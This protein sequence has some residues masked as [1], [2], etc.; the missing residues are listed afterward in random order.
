MNRKSILGGLAVVVLIGASFMLGRISLRY[1]SARV[2]S[3]GPINSDVCPRGYEP[4]DDGGAIKV[5]GKRAGTR[6]YDELVRVGEGNAAFWI[7]RYEASIWAD[8]LAATTQYGAKGHDFPEA[9][10][11]NGDWQSADGKAPVFA[12]SLKG[13]PPSANATWFQALSACM[14]SGKRLPNGDEWLRAAWGTKDPGEASGGNGECVTHN[15][16]VRGTGGGTRCRSRW[17]A[18]DMVGNLWEWTSEWYA[19]VADRTNVDLPSWSDQYGGD[20]TSNVGGT[21]EVTT[22]DGTTTGQ[23]NLPAAALRGGAL[24]QVGNAGG[25]YTFN[26]GSSP[27]AHYDVVGFRCMIPR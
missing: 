5:C 2:A 15:T 8:E 26:I 24:T 6:V 21:T 3:E 7:D 14:A 13:V 27:R 10:P 25:I 18:E 16:V 1:M 19:T 12:R 11:V 23:A 17:G 4:V 22:S 9:F 20:S